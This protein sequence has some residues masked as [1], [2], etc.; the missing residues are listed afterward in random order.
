MKLT[1]HSAAPVGWRVCLALGLL[2]LPGAILADRHLM[3]ALRPD[4]LPWLVAIMQWVTWL[5]HGG[6]DIPVPLAI[7]L[8]ERGLGDTGAWRRGCLGGLAVALAGL[9]DQ[10]VKNLLC[11]ARPPA[12]DAGA[13][14]NTFPCFPAPYAL[15]SFPSG[16][17]TTAFALATV[18]SVWY[19][20]WTLAWLVLAAMVGWSRIVLGAHFP[21]DVLAGALLGV[22]AVLWFARWFPGMVAS[23]RNPPLPPF[24]KG[25]MGGF[26]VEP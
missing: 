1:K 19:P 15:A 11:R 5:G 17:T 3:A 20:K 26:G 23:A 13:F 8:A 25:G 18:L 16:H 14:F 24:N 12:V 21:A 2:V 6:V 4:A 7:G 22:A 9:L 10:L